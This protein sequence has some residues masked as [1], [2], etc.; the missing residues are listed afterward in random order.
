M[1]N[2]ANYIGAFEGLKQEF[3][4]FVRSKIDFEL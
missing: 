2:F 4:Y 3:N 1:S